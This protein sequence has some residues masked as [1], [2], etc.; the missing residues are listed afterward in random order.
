MEIQWMNEFPSEKRNW[1]WEC[2]L[3]PHFSIVNNPEQGFA[4]G[5]GW[6]FWTLALFVDVR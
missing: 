5:I 4:M 3:I 2:E 1:Y 6:L